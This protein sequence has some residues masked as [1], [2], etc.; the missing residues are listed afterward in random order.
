[1]FKNKRVSLF[2][3]KIN[4]TTK[5]Q[6]HIYAWDAVVNEIVK[7]P[8]LME[9]MDKKKKINNYIMPFGEVM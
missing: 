3:V 4:F 1:M 8:D 9:L 7:T 5:R 2:I 6:K